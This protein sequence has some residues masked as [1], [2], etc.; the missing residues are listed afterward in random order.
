MM[1]NFDLSIAIKDKSSKYNI[2]NTSLF[3]LKQ[4]CES[5]GEIFDV[6]I[7]GGLI[8]TSIICPICGDNHRYKFSLKK[9][10]NGTVAVGGCDKLGMPILYIG[11]GIEIRNKTWKYNNLN[12]EIY[13]L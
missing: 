4:S 8:S 1:L 13:G 11:N 3:R 12:K 2:A 6:E 7:N 5:F 10:I 9:L